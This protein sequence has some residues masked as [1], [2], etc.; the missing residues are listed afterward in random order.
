[1]KKILFL[2]TLTLVLGCS[3][4]DKDCCTIIDTGVSIKYINED[5]QN[6]LGPVGRYTEADITIYHKI[7]NEWI[8][9]YKG[10]LDNPKGITTVER[11]DETYLVIFPSTTIVA[12]N[13]SETK[14]EFSESDFDI[15]KTEIDKNNS[16]Q[17]ITRVWYNNELKWE[18]LQTERIFEIVK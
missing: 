17:I 13:Y 5:G 6:L 11:Q 2:I 14:I 7:N 10:N 16:N 18:G 3:T 12:N 4:D 8:R 1:M 9:Y 15:L